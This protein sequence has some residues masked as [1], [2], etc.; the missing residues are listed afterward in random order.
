MREYDLASL[1]PLIL[2][3]D[4]PLSV[5]RQQLCVLAERSADLLIETSSD[6]S[7]SSARVQQGGVGFDVVWTEEVPALSGYRSV[8]LGAFSPVKSTLLSIKLSED[9]AGGE[10]VAPVA[11][12]LLIFGAR[13]VRELV[14]QAVMW[15][16]A[17]IISEPI[18]FAENVQNYAK[19]ETFPVLVTVDFEYENEESK[20]RS[21]G[22][23]WFS[24]Q[25]I[26]L[27]GG[28]LQG[29]NLVRRAVRL[30]HDIG[31]NGAVVA[32]QLVSDLDPDNLIE[33]MPQPDSDVLRCEIYCK[34]EST[35]RATS[36]D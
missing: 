3:F 34:T 13:L 27:S 32:H 8:F 22:L 25:E 36:V 4:Q 9:L 20:L 5:M 7:F 30:V 1:A 14:A 19:G 18:F 6:Q 31:T 10:R 35:F 26:E 16:P 28:G 11:K 2:L 17:K 29:Q 23:A 21:S 33:L 24:G 15:T 12:A